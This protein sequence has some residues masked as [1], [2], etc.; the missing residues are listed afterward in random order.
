ML[1]PLFFVFSGLNTKLGLINSPALW[2]ITLLVMFAAMAG[3]GGA[4]TVAAKICGR[5]WHESIAIGTLMNARGL[6]EL[7]ILNIGREKGVISDTMFTI[8]VLM[9]VV[10]TLI[11]SPLFEW[12]YGRK[13]PAA[14]GGVPQPFATEA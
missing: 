8:M 6:M 3:K 9:A 1:L 12:I 4:C 5:T 11:A 13:V 2:G 10:T 14:P 7:I